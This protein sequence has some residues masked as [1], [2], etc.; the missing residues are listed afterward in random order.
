[1][2]GS[3]EEPAKRRTASSTWSRPGNRPRWLVDVRANG[4]TT[5]TSATR[6]SNPTS[7]FTRGQMAVLLHR[8]A[9]GAPAQVA[10]AAVPR[11]GASGWQ[12]T[13]VSAGWPRAGHHHRHLGLTTFSPDADR[14]P[15][16]AG[17]RSC[18]A[19]RARLP[20]DARPGVRARL[21]DV[22]LVAPAST[23]SVTSAASPPPASTG[24]TSVG[25]GGS[26]PS[27]ITVD[28]I[29]GAQ[30][31]ALV[32]PARPVDGD[33]PLVVILHSWSAD[34]LTARRDSLRDVGPGERLGRD[35]H[36][37]SGAATTTRSPADPIWPSR[38]SST[39]ST[40]RSAMPASTRTERV[41]RRLLRWRGMMALVARRSPPRQ[42]HRCRVVGSTARPRR[43]LRLLAVA[44]PARLH[45][46]RSRRLC[47]GDPDG[48]RARHSE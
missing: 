3:A 11:C 41:R 28:G 21:R 17:R 26:R 5:G 13:A 20:V 22:R 30:Q 37:T 48:G 19:T 29:D 43:L 34:Y 12:V 4:I 16:P 2:E 25:A 15:R 9:E 47:G 23:R 7:R 38:T 40:S 6:Y 36:R 33:Q 10:S 35:R 8:L 42:G 45:T 18:I 1:M 39:R 44:E 24:G 27:R 46:T 14:D 31:P 32:A